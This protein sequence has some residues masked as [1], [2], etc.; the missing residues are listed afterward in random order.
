M[1]YKIE[2]YLRH[3]WSDLDITVL[4]GIKKLESITSI[5][6]ELSNETKLQRVPKPNQECKK[7]LDR[8]NVKIPTNLPYRDVEFVTR[9]KVKKEE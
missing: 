9:H 5:I 4:E 7:L 8:V 1:S 3:Y 6:I 2:R